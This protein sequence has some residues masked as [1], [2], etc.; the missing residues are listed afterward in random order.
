MELS[1]AQSKKEDY[2]E[3]N[4]VEIPLHMF[5]YRRI[6]IPIHHISSEFVIFLR[7]MFAMITL[8]WSNMTMEKPWWFSQ[9][10]F[11]VLHLVGRFVCTAMFDDI[12]G[13]S[14]I[15]TCR[16]SQEKWEQ[17]WL[18]TVQGYGTRIPNFWALWAHKIRTRHPPIW[19]SIS[20]PAGFWIPFRFLGRNFPSFQYQLT[21]GNPVT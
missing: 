14:L 3:L 2:I 1:F 7:S 5:E 9:N 10:K 6:I 4:L 19:G 18:P 20:F 12:A 13:Y 11:H 17:L 8:S 15:R 16:T 21:W